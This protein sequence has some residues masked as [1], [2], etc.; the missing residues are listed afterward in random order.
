WFPIL[1]MVFLRVTDPKFTGT[2][3]KAMQSVLNDNP[4]L[5]PPTKRKDGEKEPSEVWISRYSKSLGL[6]YKQGIQ[7]PF[8]APTDRSNPS[9]PVR[10]SSEFIDFYCESTQ[11]AKVGKCYADPRGKNLPKIRGPMVKDIFN[12]ASSVA[13]SYEVV[14]PTG[15]E[16]P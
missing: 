8:A 4:H 9:A 3:R 2:E 7:W 11:Y 10:P 16:E 14:P 13:A 15:P 1:Y 6:A 5:L 12:W